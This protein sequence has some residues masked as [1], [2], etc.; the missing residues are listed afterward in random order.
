[1]PGSEELNFLL[2][3]IITGELATVA[4]L[5]GNDMYEKSENTKKKE[6][7][8]LK[9]YNRPENMTYDQLKA[10]R[11]HTMKTSDF[12]TKAYTK[13]RIEQIDAE[14]DKRFAAQ[15]EQEKRLQAERDAQA[16][17]VHEQWHA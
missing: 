8:D 10:E 15:N 5:K 12:Y 17:V 9:A 16:T 4:A 11:K 14:I 3:T 6:F 2:G 13:K 7:E 1:M